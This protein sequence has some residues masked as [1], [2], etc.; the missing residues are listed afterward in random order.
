MADLFL[1][2]VQNLTLRNQQGAS[3]TSQSSG[4]Q[5]LSL[6]QTHVS[7]QPTPLIKTPSQSAS[8]SDTGKSNVNAA[9]SD[10]VKKGEEGQTEMK[11]VNM[12]RNVSSSHPLIAP[13]KLLHF[14]EAFFTSVF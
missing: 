3:S 2:Q 14:A 4:L 6:K 1:S 8:S 5:A 13:G 10:G 7:I 9:S 11:A 12:S